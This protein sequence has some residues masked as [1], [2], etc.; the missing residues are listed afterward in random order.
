MPAFKLWLK[1][2]GLGKGRYVVLD[3][4]NFFYPKA[5]TPIPVTDQQLSAY[6]GHYYCKENDFA[7]DIVLR[8]HK[9]K[10]TNSRYDDADISFLNADEVFDG[11]WWMDHLTM[12]R[13]PAGKITGFEVNVRSTYH[14]RYDKLG[15]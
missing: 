7:F 9:L 4:I 12:L 15:R 6:T 1:L 13:N 8:D 14:L 2:E 3:V 5:K 11:N 10:L